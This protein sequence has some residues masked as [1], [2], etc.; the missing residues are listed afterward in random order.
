MSQIPGCKEFLFL[1]SRS[2]ESKPMSCRGPSQSPPERGHPGHD[3][4]TLGSSTLRW[5]IL[6]WLFWTLR[7]LGADGQ[8]SERLAVASSAPRAWPCPSRRAPPPPLPRRCPTCLS[9]AASVSSRHSQ[10]CPATCLGVR[11]PRHPAPPFSNSLNVSHLGAT[12]FTATQDPRLWG[13]QATGRLNLL[14]WPRAGRAWTLGPQLC[15]GQQAP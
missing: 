12:P 1:C 5:G 3:R 6:S 15:R 7:Q 11:E 10:V 2:W 8:V 13:S 9:G 14:P 4:N